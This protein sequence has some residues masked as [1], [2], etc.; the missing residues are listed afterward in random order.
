MRQF[1]RIHVT[2]ISGSGKT[3]VAGRIA[4]RLGIPYIELDALHWQPNW[5]LPQLEDFRAKVAAALAPEAWVLEGNYRKVQDLIWPRAQ[6]VIFLDLPLALTLWRL[7]RRT[8]GRS[9]RNE[10]L[11]AGN[12]ENLWTTFFTRESLIYYALRVR[13]RLKQRFEQDRQ[14]PN[15]RHIE[16]LR[17][18]SDREISAYIQ[19]L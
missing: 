14:D 12:R 15:L 7:M 16:F 1:R 6:Q 18:S 5:Q 3:T 10:V 17:L 8:V 11:W 9:L 2:G 4:G 19:S 13:K